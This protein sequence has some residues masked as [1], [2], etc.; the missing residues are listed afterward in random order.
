MTWI[1]EA[2]SSGARPALACNEAYI[3]L[4]TYRRWHVKGQVRQDLRPDSTRPV[5]G[6]K[7]SEQEVS[8]LLAICNSLKYA[9]LPPSQ[10]VPRLADEGIFIASEST[11]YRVLKQQGQLEHRS[12]AKQPQR[13]KAPTTY[14]ACRPNQLWSWDISYCPSKVKGQFYYLYLFEDIFSR[15]IV[16]FEV[17][18]EERG[19]HAAA[20]LQRTVLQERCFK[21]TTPIVLH[22]DNGAPMKSQT[23]KAKME[24]LG[25]VSSY[26]R[27]R[28]SHDNPYSEALFR[29]L[30]YCPTWPS[31]GFNSLD[32][33]RIWV[34]RFVS[35]YN[36]THRHSQ[37]GF[38]TPAQ[39][40]QGEDEVL[41]AQRRVV[42]HAAQH[43]NPLR[44]SRSIRNWS[45]VDM[46]TLNP[47]KK[48]YLQ[49]ENA[50]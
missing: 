2:I 12:R 23:L 47:E 42:K 7:L 38:V 32:E 39:K 35:W 29:T 19:E 40:H 13:N 33:A 27:P 10:I 4:R 6:N 20:L 50:E 49:P 9:S 34:T 25:V 26:S 30:K 36:E 21:N 43:K 22:S 16:G 41:L 14:S 11:F 28:V 5:A 18:D 37:I 31:P 24:E 17:Y 15:K 1:K 46:V 45:R 44:W 48:E 3:S 8:E